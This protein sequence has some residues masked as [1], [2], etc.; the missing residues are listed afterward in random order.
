MS[1]LLY[2]T[3]TKTKEEFRPLRAGEVTMYTCGPTVYSRP[4]I[5]NYASFLL[6]DLLRRWLEVLGFTVKHVKNITD[7]GHLSAD[8]EADAGGEDKM[9]K[10]ARAENCDPLDV[11]QKYTE[12]YL[13]DERALNLLEPFARPR[14]TET[15][16]GMIDMIRSLMEKGRAYETEDGIYFAV[17]RFPA[18]GALSGNTLANL[19]KL[20]QGV[21]VALKESKKH[22]ADFALWKKCVGENAYH[23][24]RWSFPEGERLSGTGED[25][26]AGFPGWHIECSVMSTNLLGVEFDIHTGGEDLI[27]PHHECEIAQSQSASGKLPARYWVHRRF[28]DL[29]EQK[30]SK[31][32][33]NIL[34]LPHIVERGFSPLDL[35]Y[36]LLSAH[37][38]S[39]SQFTWKALEDA[40][41]A[42]LR[43]GEW[44]GERGDLD[45]LDGL[46]DCEGLEGGVGEFV[47]A[48][49]DD[50]NTPAALAAVFELMAASRRL[51]SAC[52]I[53]KT[54]FCLLEHTFGCFVEDAVAI[55]VEIHKLSDEREEARRAGDY[56]RADRLRSEALNQGYVI[57][58]LPDGPSILPKERRPACR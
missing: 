39:H 36:L 46:E 29:D 45:G 54:F 22:P 50:L 4:H 21:R 9:E 51:K 44:M 37:Y 1:L 38:R 13:D 23:I 7:V 10:A 24:L 14:A 26:T 25:P 18:Y 30:M 48:M 56:Q 11:A 58:D 16:R 5:G 57:E 53:P 17:E 47:R 43:V 19:G 52:R 32:K 2:N 33:G 34:N 8:Q 35:R 28:V 42:R 20:A 6:A 31:A 27:F 40:R 12:Q 15:I 55:P 41:K 49:N 3:L